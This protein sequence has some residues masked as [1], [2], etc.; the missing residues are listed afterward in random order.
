MHHHE[1]IETTQ[2]TP[3]AIEH[4][5]KEFGYRLTSPRAAVVQAVL[6]HQRPFTAEQLVAELGAGPQAIGRATVYRTLEV[7]ASVDVIT[8][9]VSPDGHPSYISGSPGHRHHLLCQNCGTTVTFTAC[10]M[11]DLINDLAKDTN[12][13]IQD[14]TLEVFGVCPDCA[15]R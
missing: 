8:R 11:P 1:P 13:L 12:F 4:R 7:L 5:L 2:L 10:P 9:I 6:A 14:H 15:A 3:E